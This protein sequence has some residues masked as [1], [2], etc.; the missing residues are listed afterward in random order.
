MPGVVVEMVED[1]GAVAV[2]VVSVVV[3]VTA[4]SVVVLVVSVVVE[5]TIVVAVQ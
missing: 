4:G 3:D 2:V 1:V 5:V